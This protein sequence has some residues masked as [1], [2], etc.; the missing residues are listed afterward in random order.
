MKDFIKKLFTD[1]TT[2]PDNITFSSKRIA[3]F[4]ALISTLSYAFFKKGAD[5][6]I[7]FSLV[8]LTCT[9]W[10]LTSV[11]KNIAAKASNTSSTDN[12]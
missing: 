9:F 7:M 10:G 12:P 4:I 8:G 6:D 2:G 11:D 1:I 3:G 5:H